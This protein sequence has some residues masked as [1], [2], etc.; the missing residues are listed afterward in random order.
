MFSMRQETEVLQA[1]HS[2]VRSQEDEKLVF[3]NAF[4]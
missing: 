4:E 1:V 3:Y 2:K